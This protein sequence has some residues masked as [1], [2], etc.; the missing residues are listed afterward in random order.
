MFNIELK[1]VRLEL[2]TSLYLWI[3]SK[4]SIVYHFTTEG[5]ES[6]FLGVIA[7]NRIVNWM[8]N[9]SKN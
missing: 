4:R 7:L 2:L 5:I 3:L 9:A 6:H 8:Q 1:S